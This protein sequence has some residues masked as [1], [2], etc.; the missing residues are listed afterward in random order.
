MNTGKTLFA[1]LMDFLPWTTFTRIVDRSGW[2]SHWKTTGSGRFQRRAIP[3]LS[4][5]SKLYHRC[6]SASRSGAPGRWPMNIQRLDHRQLSTMGLD[7][8]NTVYAEFSLCV[9]NKV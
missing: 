3:R 5:A 9:G 8:R 7:G 1:Q 4:K 6:A 2:R